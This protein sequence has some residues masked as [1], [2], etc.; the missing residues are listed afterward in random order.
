[1]SAAAPTR[2]FGL[3][4]CDRLFDVESYLQVMVKLDDQDELGVIKCCPECIECM[5]RKPAPFRVISYFRGRY[6][7]E[8]L[9]SS[10]WI[11]GVDARSCPL[12]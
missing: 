3:G 1:M 7:A 8:T 10:A 9:R 11:M 2:Q 12:P 4:R 5:R 6:R